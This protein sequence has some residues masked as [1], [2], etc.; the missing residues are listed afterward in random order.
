MEMNL[1]HSVFWF[2]MGVVS[3]RIASRMFGLILS[4]NIYHEVL[5]TVLSLVKYTD[6][7]IQS[8]LEAHYEVMEKSKIDQEEIEKRKIVDRAL[9][10]GW[11]QLV[12]DTIVKTCPKA[13]R[14]SLR[15]SNWEQAMTYHTKRLSTK[16]E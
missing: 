13:L 2:L 14:G 16:E 11:K 9:L 1:Y 6:N 12:I 10:E 8:A 7:N 4:L 3:Y 15:F 5:L